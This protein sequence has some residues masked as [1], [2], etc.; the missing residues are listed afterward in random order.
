MTSLIMKKYIQKATRVRNRINELALFNDENNE[1]HF[2]SRIFGSAAFVNCSIRIAQWMEEAGLKTRIDN[3][4]NVRGKLASKNPEAKTLVIAS[5]FDPDIYSGKYDGTLGIIMAIDIIEN[6]K[7]KNISLPFH[8]EVIAF[9]E[10]EGNR[11]HV[12]YLGS[13]VIAG[14]FKNKWF[15]VKD[16]EG[17]TLQNVLQSLNYDVSHIKEDAIA[18]NDWLGYYEIHIEQGNSLYEKKLP[19]GIVST[20]AGQKIIEIIFTGESGNAGSIPMNKRRDALGAAAKFISS[21]EKYASKEKR[22]MV[23]TVGRIN[24]HNAASNVIP[25][26]VSCTLDLRAQDAYLLSEAYEDINQ[27]CEKI[28]TKR[29]IYFEWKLIHETEPVL[30][31][32][33]LRKLLSNAIA[34]KNIEP[35]DIISGA[36]QDA[37]IISRIAPVCMLFIKCFLGE[38]LHPVETVELEDIAVGLEVSDHFILQL[39]QAG[40]DKGIKKK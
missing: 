6:L 5:H 29:N 7:E 17:N 30:C 18:A 14:S 34:E 13:Q 40:P 28:C 35:T 32:K 16:S 31:S 4:G 39:A 19:V 20:I 12:P 1:V 36:G 33:K 22:N 24:I 37:V 21:T 8:I 25:A 3:I 38:S 11:F 23:A 26:K 2:T 27:L 10:R 9:S 15:D